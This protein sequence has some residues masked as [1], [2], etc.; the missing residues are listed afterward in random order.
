MCKNRHRKHLVI[1]NRTYDIQA[2]T[3]NASM[4]KEQD[5]LSVLG[6]IIVPWDAYKEM[7]LSGIG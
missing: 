4:H 7:K 5:I 1:S 3:L 2:Y 6:T